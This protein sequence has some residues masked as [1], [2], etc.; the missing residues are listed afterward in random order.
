MHSSWKF[1]GRQNLW[2]AEYGARLEQEGG[3]DIKMHSNH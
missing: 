1:L 2:V 3:L